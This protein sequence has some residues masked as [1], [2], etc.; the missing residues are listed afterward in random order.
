MMCK[1]R[2]GWVDG[3]H[4][5]PVALPAFLARRQRLSR[6]R[7]SGRKETSALSPGTLLRSALRWDSLPLSGSAEI[8]GACQD[9]SARYQQR[10]VCDP[11][12]LPLPWSWQLNLTRK[13]KHF[14]LLHTVGGR[15]KY[16]SFRTPPYVR[17]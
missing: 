11:R 12:K 13:T 4:I 6:A 14:V 16:G 9:L 17:N 5:Q 1:V 10:V 7:R 8:A 15:W 2:V 3:R